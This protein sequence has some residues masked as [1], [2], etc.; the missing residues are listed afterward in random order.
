MKIKSKDFRVLGIAFDGAN[1]WVANAGDNTV[2]ELQ[3]SN[4]MNLGTFNAGSYPWGVAFDGANIWVTNY[5]VGTVTKLQASTG[6]VLGTFTVGA[7]PQGIAF[8]SLF[9]A[10]TMLQ[11]I[12]REDIAPWDEGNEDNDH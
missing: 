8:H 6:T 4:G 1:I 3:A 9:P 5:N 12:I 2:T 7:D 10:I 11:K